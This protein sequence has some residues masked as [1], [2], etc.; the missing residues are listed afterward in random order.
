MISTQWNVELGQQASICSKT[1]ENQRKLW[2][3]LPV[4]G[5]CYLLHAGFL[6]GLFFSTLKMETVYSSEKS[7]DIQRTTWYYML[8]DRAL[9]SEQDSH[10]FYYADCVPASS[11]H[12]SR[13]SAWTWGGCIQTCHLFPLHT[14]RAVVKTWAVTD[15]WKN[16]W[17]LARWP[18][19]DSRQV[20]LF[21]SLPSRQKPISDSLRLLANGNESLLHWVQNG[22]SVNLNIYR[23]SR[24][25][26]T[27]SMDL[28]FNDM[29]L[30]LVL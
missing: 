2:L 18:G 6:P 27:V 29:V 21:I 14:S 8:E 30:K 1:D 17:L 9:Q 5:L 28:H 22:Y 11:R 26:G 7:V 16:D 12:I 10:S 13:T 25:K 24:T 20:K 19:F 15:G 4:A 3:N 23:H